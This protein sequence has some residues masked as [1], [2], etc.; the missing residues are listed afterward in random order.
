VDPGEDLELEP[1]D[2]HDTA[3]HVTAGRTVR[4][5]L[6]F[7]RDIDVFCVDES[8]GT[9]IDVDDPI[10]RAHGAVLEVTPMG[11]ALDGVPVRVHAPAQK[12]DVTERD[13]KSPWKS[14]K[15]GAPPVCVSL[16]LVP[17]IWTP[18]PLPRTA[19]ASDHEYTV[20]VVKL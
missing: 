8:A 3:M 9:Q 15:R 12:G 11:G 16:T 5:R 2:A 10:P 20:R 18:P 17:D 14:P 13:V 4:G 19:P 6:S 7:M 1:N